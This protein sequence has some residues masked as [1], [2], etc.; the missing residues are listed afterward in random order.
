MSPSKNNCASTGCTVEA[1][2]I[3]KPNTSNSTADPGNSQDIGTA[4]HA[5]QPGPRWEPPP[6][7]AA[8][9]MLQRCW[10]SL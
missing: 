7:G 8:V 6:G 10:G 9:A 5:N 4:R 1:R 3:T 2:G